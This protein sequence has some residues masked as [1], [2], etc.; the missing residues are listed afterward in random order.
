MAAEII[1]EQRSV[2]FGYFFL[3]FKKYLYVG[4]PKSINRLLSITYR[5]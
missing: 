4:F 3:P 1:N 5:S 2:F